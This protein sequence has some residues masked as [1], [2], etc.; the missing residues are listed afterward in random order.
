MSGFEFGSYFPLPPFSHEAK[1]CQRA[2]GGIGRHDGLKIRFSRESAG[3]I[4][5]SPTILNKGDSQIT[6]VAFFV[7]DPSPSCRSPMA[8][9]PAKENGQDGITPTRLGYTRQTPSEPTH[10]A[11][12]PTTTMRVLVP[13]AA[14]RLATSFHP[15]RPV[16]APP[17]LHFYRPSHRL[18][19]P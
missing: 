2:S 8:M 17:Q 15:Q 3:S 13:V 11:S 10:Y 6:R 16:K 19:P 7:A 9:P 5:A 18:R 12:T 14:D 4:P 1:R